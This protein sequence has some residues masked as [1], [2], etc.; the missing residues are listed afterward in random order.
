MS[1]K[2][3]KWSKSRR[4]KQDDF[5]NESE[6]MSSEAAAAISDSSDED[7]SVRSSSG[8]EESEVKFPYD[9]A[10]WDLSQCDPKKC[11]GRKLARL[12]F[13]RCLK[14]S[15]RFTGVVL[16][17]VASKCIGPDDRDVIES[18][19]LGVVRSCL[20]TSILFDNLYLLSL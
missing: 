20:Y 7:D 4:S 9:L 8:E 11:S 12:G 10:M 13:V 18:S 14:L 16:T 3:V 15:Q 17:P 19:G 1:R 2:D 6:R 5:L